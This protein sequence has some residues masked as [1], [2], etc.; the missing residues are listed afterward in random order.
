MNSTARLIVAPLL[1]ALALGLMPGG[2]AGQVYNV[3]VLTDASPDYHDLD[4][5]VRSITA[6]WETPEE[7]CWAVFYWNHKARRQTSPMVLHG[8]A[9]TDPIRQFNDYGYTMCSTISGMNCSIW[10]AMGLTPRYWDIANHTVSE[11]FYDGGW[12]LYDNSMSAI[13]TLCDGRTIAGVEDIGQRGACAASGGKEELGHVAKYHCLTA[14][15]PNGFLTGADCARTLDGQARCFNPNALKY[16]SYFFD[17]DRGHRYILN[18]KPGEVHTRHYEALGNEPKHYVPNRGRDPEATEYGTGRFRIR[19][20]GRWVFAPKWTPG[21]LARAAHSTMNVRALPEGGLEPEKPGEPAEAVFKIDGA[22][23][24]TSMAIR[25]DFRRAGRDDLCAIA[26]STTNGLAWREVWRAEDAGPSTA[27]V[28]LIDEVNG[29]YEVLVKVQLRAARAT[30]DARLDRLE[31]ETL[32]MLNSKTQPKLLLG[33]NTVH[34]GA[35][36]QTGSIVFWPE[37]QADRWKPYAVEHQ[38]VATREKHPGYQGVMHAERPNEEAYVVYR[39]DAPRPLRQ[40]TYGGRFYNRAPKSHIA[41]MHSFDGGQTWT[42]TWSLTDTESPWDVIHY[43]TVTDIPPGARSVLLK[44]LWNSSAAGTSACSI[45]AVRMEANYEP[46]LGA[47]AG[48]L[49]VTFAWAEVQPDRSLVERSHTELVERLPHRYKLRTGGADHPV[50]RWV[51]VNLKGAAPTARYGYSDG[52]DAPAERFVP[53]WVTYG[54][55]LAEGKPYTV[56]IPSDE[57]WGSGDPEG[58]KL[59]DGVVGSPYAGGTAPQSCLCWTA[60]KEPEITVDLGKPQRC[61]AFRIHLTGYPFWDAMKGEVQDG[62]EV[63]TSLDGE[64][65]TSQGPFDLQLW[66]KDLPVNHFWPDDERFTGPVFELI[67]PRPVEARWVRFKL[68]SKRFLMTSEVQVLDRIDYKPFDLRLA[69]P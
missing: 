25:A 16:R 49:E 47:V 56:S 37:L 42:K 44:Y 58:T 57:H 69:L 9:V 53:R 31:I 55:N 30:A 35:G 7:K 52:R 38:N 27:E 11:V 5:M 24:I 39:I 34:V 48:P 46:P 4:G 41:L 26:L 36:D 23:A 33:E 22:N 28:E 62:V 50:V 18:L 66:W 67:P 54:R 14:T 68:K 51:Q 12:R 6:R 61:G 19:G 13:Y 10:H 21:E 3:K 15:S 45:Y 59:T 63:F 20:N 8:M 29:A 65:F 1:A 2:A 17:W 40:V 43:E 64:R 60:G 32:T